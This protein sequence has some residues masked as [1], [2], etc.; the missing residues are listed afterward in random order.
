MRN[1]ARHRVGATFIVV[2]AVV[3]VSY[4]DFEDFGVFGDFEDFGVFGDFE[5][6][7]DFGI[8]EDF[9]D[10]AWTSSVFFSRPSANSA[11]PLG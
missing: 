5:D 3:A 1:T 11:P 6:L 2:A 4:R 8:F 9:V 7:G 10:L